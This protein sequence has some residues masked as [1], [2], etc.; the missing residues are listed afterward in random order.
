MVG[1]HGI[2]IVGTKEFLD[3]TPKT[4]RTFKYGQM[5]G[6]VLLCVILL[7]QI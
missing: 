5:V 6:H 1:G 2:V 4:R 3:N 7:S